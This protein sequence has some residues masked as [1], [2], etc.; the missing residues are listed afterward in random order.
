[1]PPIRSSRA[2]KNGR[3][4]GWGNF[5]RS[6]D[7]SASPVQ[8]TAPPEYGIYKFDKWIKTTNG[9]YEEISTNSITIVPGNHSRITAQY[10]KDV[11]ELNVPDTLYV[12]WAQTSLDI[13]VK[14][15]N[16]T[17]H[18]V[19]GWFS[20]TTSEWFSIS[21]GTVKGEEDG[22]ITLLFSANEGDLRKG[23]VSVYAF[24]ASN[25]NKK[26]VII[27]GSVGTSVEPVTPV[28]QM[29]AVYPVP[30]REEIRLSLPDTETGKECLI[31]V[32]SMGGRNVYTQRIKDIS[33]D[34]SIGLSGIKPGVYILKIVVD[35]KVYIRRFIKL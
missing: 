14:N 7:N 31:T 23:T 33:K 1:M 21:E 3:Y 18:M 5:T 15:L 28:E 6:Y 16:V 4:H 22:T 29:I 25:P 27:Q 17:G 8:F 12:D 20:E 13:P 34:H 32:L 2:D 10:R 26:V 11:P 35:G 19:M 24:N 30:A 9:N